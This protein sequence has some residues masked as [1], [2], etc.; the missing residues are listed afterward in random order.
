[1][2]KEKKNIVRL[3]LF[4]MAAG[5]AVFAFTNGVLQ[6]G[7]RESGYQAIDYET[8]YGHVL[9]K[10]GISLRYWAEGDSSKIREL[11]TAV[12]KVYSESLYRNYMMLDAR[13]TYESVTNLA[14]LNKSPGESFV[15]PETL[16][17]ILRDAWKKTERNE[18]YSVLA[19]VMYDEWQ[20]LLYLDDALEFDPSADAA[21]AEFLKTLAAWTAPDSGVTLEMEV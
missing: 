11:T 19:G 6:L 1:M 5:L 21:R 17:R 13:E 8:A 3:I 10:S 16:A 4:L 14:T 7:H 15:L 20:T 9:Y 12:Q 18:G 2:F